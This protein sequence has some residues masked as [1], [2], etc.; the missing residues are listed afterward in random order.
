MPRMP[1]NADAPTSQTSDT[2]AFRGL[3]DG[4]LTVEEQFA[5]ISS[6]PNSMAARTNRGRAGPSR[7]DPAAAHEETSM[8]HQIMTDLGT[9]KELQH[10]VGDAG[11]Q[12]V[13]MEKEMAVEK[14]NGTGD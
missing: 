2:S 12:V 14:A 3:T 6:N 10:K 9:V 5:L 11:K 1:R 4:N 8:W 13:Q 7:E